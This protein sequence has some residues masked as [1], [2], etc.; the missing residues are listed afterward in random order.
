MKYLIST[1]C[2]L[3]ALANTASAQSDDANPSDKLAKLVYG[4]IDE[5]PTGSVDIGAFVEFG[6]SIFVSMDYDDSGSVNLKEFTDWD[7][8]FNFIAANAGQE[9]AFRAAQKIL[10]SIW[11]HDGNGEIENEEYNKSMIWDFRRADIDGDANLTREEFLS[12]YVINIAYRAA[13][14]GN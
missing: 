6:K 1:G 12:G 3:L 13:I 8:G 4:S 11:D 14:T 7:F 5:N 9:H 10:F 2:L